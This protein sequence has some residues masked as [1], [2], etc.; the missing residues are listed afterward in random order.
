MLSK[1]LQN[2]VSVSTISVH[3]L[4]AGKFVILCMSD[5]AKRDYDS[6][7]LHSLLFILAHGIL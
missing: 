5:V 3:Y 7:T 1:V 6:Q 4:K 2:D